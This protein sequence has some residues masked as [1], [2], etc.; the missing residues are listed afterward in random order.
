MIGYNIM[1]C[2]D[3]SGVIIEFECMLICDIGYV[4]ILSVIC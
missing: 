2:E 4:G 1:D 3:G